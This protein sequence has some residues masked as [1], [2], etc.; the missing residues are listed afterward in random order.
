[1]TP[2]QAVMAA[3]DHIET[4]PAQFDFLTY[5]L[6]TGTHCG[7]PGCALGWIAFFGLVEG[8]DAGT[9]SRERLREFHPLLDERSFYARM[10][11]IAPA[12]RFNEKCP[13]FNAGQYVWT[14][15]PQLC[16]E[17]L[18]KYA[19]THLAPAKQPVAVESEVP[20]HV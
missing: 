7:T 9:W 10:N 15:D 4:N 12:K 11:A 8:A 3:A 2:Y 1:M 20:A 13:H 18:R 17:T 19:Q 14:Q 16:A 5:S 6:P